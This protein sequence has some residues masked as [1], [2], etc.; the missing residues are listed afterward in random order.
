MEL[1][2]K[3]SIPPRAAEKPASRPAT[4]TK[5]ESAKQRII[6][7]AE[8]LFSQYG[9]EAAS[10]R[11]IAVAAN[12]Q[13]ASMYYHFPSKDA[14]LWAVWEKGGI[15]LET[16]VHSALAEASDDPWQRLEVA[17]TAHV[18]GLLDRAS[19]FQVLFIMPPWHYPA[20]IR[21]KVIALRD[22]YESIFVDLI[23][24]LPLPPDVDRHYV[25]LTLIGALSWPLFWFKA[26][27]DSPETIA[28]NIF[29]IIKNGLV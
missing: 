22:R 24:A 6:E 29:A 26:E 15:E 17:C 8:G 21:D 28:R 27:R 1:K 2:N 3:L 16:L 9:F 14:I 18:H 20:S 4:L 19:A 13:A 12:M 11:D 23:A 25:R 7:V 5:G 10:M